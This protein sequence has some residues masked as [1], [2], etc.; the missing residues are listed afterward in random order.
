MNAPLPMP[1]QVSNL[2]NMSMPDFNLS[3]MP[4]PLPMSNMQ[5]PM[6][7]TDIPMSNMPTPN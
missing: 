6:P 2:N 4:T 1:M 7:N 3:G 5:M